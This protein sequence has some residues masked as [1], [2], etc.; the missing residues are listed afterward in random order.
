MVKNIQIYSILKFPYNLIKNESNIFLLLTIFNIITVLLEYRDMIFLP[1]RESLKVVIY[2]SCAL[3]DVYLLCFILSSIKSILWKR[4]IRW[5]LYILASSIF[6]VDIF[7]FYFYEHVTDVYMINVILQSDPN[8]MYEYLLT[9]VFT[10]RTIL[11]CVS[12]SA[13][14][15][16]V[17]NL[18]RLL[19]R[20]KIYTYIISFIIFIVT[21]NFSIMVI[22][23]NLAFS[24][25]YM[26]IARV[27]IGFLRQLNA[28]KSYKEIYKIMD[29]VNDLECQK[30]SV[31]HKM[32]LDIV[33]ILGESC[34]RSHMSLYGYNLKTTPIMDKL[35]QDNELL[36]FDDIISCGNN[37]YMSMAQIFNF[38][39]K[40]DVDFNK[41]YESPN[42]IDIFRRAS[43]RTVWITNQAGDGAMNIDTIYA[44]RSNDSA[45]TSNA[46]TGG[47][48]RN[49]DENL[50]PLIDMSIKNEFKNN[51]YVIHLEGEH[52]PYYL[53]YPDSFK[54][55][56]SLDFKMEEKENRNRIKASYDNA[57]Y[58][59]DYIYGQILDRFRNKN[60]VVFYFSD[61]GEDVCLNNDYYGHTLENQGSL[62][63]IEI[64]FVVWASI[65]FKENFGK[66]YISL[67]QSIHRPL[68]TDYLI[69]TILQLAGIRTKSFNERL[70]LIS[71]KFDEDKIRLYN[72][73]KYLKGRL[74]EK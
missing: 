25:R 22:H 24:Q 69:H 1:Y 13:F 60:S 26:S 59:T 71:S 40:D 66:E 21:L 62:Q 35:S 23:H 30:M 37:T 18:S 48:S 74:E 10:F 6:I 8:T 7:C 15:A 41:W 39:E 46:V 47:T 38:V 11:L 27:S 31:S 67:K 28:N 51:L 45:F 64:P 12:V 17:Y 70:S 65:S 43:Y 61:H 63:M 50:L 57:V 20:Y 36:V 58:Y 72:K 2:V 3:F 56:T 54:R 5:L 29:E 32:P 34:T 42:I 44:D 33:I 53:R 4:I 14:I 68:R 9:Y 16:L 49:Y 55:F 52:P 19:S 73:K